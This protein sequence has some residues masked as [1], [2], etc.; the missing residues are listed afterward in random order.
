MGLLIAF[1]AGCGR[2]VAPPGNTIRVRSL[3]LQHG[4]AIIVDNGTSNAIS[5]SRVVT[6]E[7][8]NE[9]HWSPVGA[10]ALYLRDRCT[11]STGAIFEPPTCVDV[12]ASSSFIAAGW[13][14]TIGESQCLCEECGPA[15]RGRYRFVVT[16]CDGAKRF[17]SAPFEAGE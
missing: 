1:G 13:N 9:G 8:E 14:D 15:K 7:T 3:L 12:L 2:A 5:L 10:E 6:V 11:T 16:S 17:E 4:H